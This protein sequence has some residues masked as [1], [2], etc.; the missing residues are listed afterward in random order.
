MYQR[1]LFSNIQLT[2]FYGIE[3][4]DFAHEVAMLSLWLAQHQMNMKFKEEFGQSNPTLPLKDGGNI[5]H[6]NATRLDWEVICPKKLNDEIYIIGNPPYLGARV[7]KQEQKDDLDFVFKGFKKYRDL[8]YI[9]CWFFIAANYIKDFDSK[10]AFVSTNSICQGDQVFLLWPAIFA[11]NLEL[12]F[13]HQSFKWENNA[14]AQAAVI[15][16]IIG[17]RNISNGKKYIYKGLLKKEVKNINAYLIEESNFIIQRRNRPLSQL[18]KMPKGNMPYDGG[19]LLL[20][21]EE[22]SSLVLAFPCSA[23][24]IKR[25]V[26]AKEYISNLERWCLWIPDGLLSEALEIQPIK[27]RIDAVRKERLKSSDEGAQKL[28]KRAH[29][30]REV[31]ETKTSSIVIPLATSQRRKYVPIGFI[32]SDTIVTNLSC[33]IYD[34]EPYI[35]GIISSNMHMVWMKIVAGRL[36]SDYRY[37]PDLCYNTFPFPVIMLTQ[38]KDLEKYV[39]RIIEERETYSEKTLGELYDPDKMPNGLKEA[40]EQLDLAIERCYRSKLFEN[41]EE[42]LAYLF[43]MYEQMIADEKTNGTLFETEKK[44]KKSKTFKNA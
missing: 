15:V 5:T 34:A 3:L 33:V 11:F 10:L 30:F 12:Y 8:D 14:K 40:H 24:F 1:K 2:Q 7:Q 9:A 21:P 44:I 32:G 42:R 37:S 18:P 19:H 43:K 22:R 35:F 6:G 39:F 38:K 4:D 26:G 28:A 41:D 13:A 27:D 23:K 25:L 17:L 29:Q 31:N 36:K 16:S 20:T